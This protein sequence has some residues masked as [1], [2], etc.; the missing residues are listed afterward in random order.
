LF[1][2]MVLLFACIHYQQAFWT[3][4]FLESRHGWNYIFYALLFTVA[5]I[6]RLYR[7]MNMPISWWTLQIRRNLLSTRRYENKD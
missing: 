4:A 3:D 2:L 5:M 1:E 7:F 6:L